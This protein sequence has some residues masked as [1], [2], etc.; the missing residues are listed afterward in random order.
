MTAGEQK[1]TALA[2]TTRLSGG[3]IGVAKVIQLEFMKQ[4]NMYYSIINK[5]G[6]RL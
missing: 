1:Q 3:Q 4:I 6:F 2:S 5:T